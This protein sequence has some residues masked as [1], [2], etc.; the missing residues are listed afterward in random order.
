MAMQAIGLTIT[1][2]QP[3]I[4]SAATVKQRCHLCPR[5]RDRK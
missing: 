2:S 3:T 1:T 5:E 4:V